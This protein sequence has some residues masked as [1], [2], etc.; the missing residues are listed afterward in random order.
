SIGIMAGLYLGKAIG[1]VSL[2]WLLVRA[3]WARLQTGLRWRHLWAA[4]FLGGIGFTMSMFITNLAF[5]EDALAI[6][7][8]ISILTASTLAALTG[9]LLFFTGKK[10]AEADQA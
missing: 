9:L 3:S 7:S 6:S 5:G 8:K 2:P 10:T 1:I 4:G